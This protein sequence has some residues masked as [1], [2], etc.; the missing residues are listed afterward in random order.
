M[1]RTRRPSLS[2]GKI[3]EATDAFVQAGADMCICLGD[4]VDRGERRGEAAECMAEAMNV[5]RSCGIPYYIVPG[6]HD[7]AALSAEE[8][9]RYTECSLPP[10]S[11]CTGTHTLIFLDANYT[12]DC[13]R[14]SEAGFDWKDSNLPCEQLDFLADTLD[15]ACTPCVVFVHEDLDDGVRKDHVVKNAS[16][17]REIIEKS[18]KVSLVIQGHYHRGADSV[19]NNIRYLTLP[20]MC[21]GE[22][23]HYVIINL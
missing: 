19:I 10:Y 17:A 20:A 9:S 18:G 21:E 5:I 11:I 12:S 22:D 13:R 2:L 14:Y 6:N 16:D 8:F 23:N 3:R 7:C 1:C 4:L 15:K